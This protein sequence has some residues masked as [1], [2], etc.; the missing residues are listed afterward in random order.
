MQI[1]KKIVLIVLMAVATAAALLVRGHFFAR[2][3]IRNVVL[4][5]IDTCRADYLGC[6]GCPLK[7]T[8]RIDSIAKQGVLF[9]YAITP[10]PITLPAHTSMLTGTTPLYHRV[11]DN[12][13]YYVG[14]H[15]VNLAQILGKYRYST[16]AFVSTAILDSEYG[17]DKGFQIYEDHFTEPS[18]Q[19]QAVERKGGE[20]TRLAI[21]W[22]GQHRSEKFFLF[23]HYY[24]PHSLYAPPQ[25]FAYLFRDNLYAGEI[26]YVDDCIG[27]VVDARKEMNLDDS[28]LL[29]ITADHGEMLGEHGEKTHAY[30][31]YQSAIKV[32]LIFKLPGRNRAVRIKEAVG[33]IDIAPTICRL[34][35]IDVLPAMQGQDLSALLRGKPAKSDE[36]FLYCESLLPTK[37]KCNPLLGVVSAKWKYIHT[38]R[39]EL[40]DLAADPCEQ[41]NLAASDAKRAHLLNEH[42][43][44]MLAEMTYTEGGSAAMTGDDDA[45][46]RLESLGYIAGSSV[47]DSLQLDPNRQDPKDFIE[48]HNMDSQAVVATNNKR[49]D[50]AK[51]L[52]RRMLARKSDYAMPYVYLGKVAFQQGD[53]NEGFVNY[54]KYLEITDPNWGEANKPP[55]VYARLGQ[56]NFYLHNIHAELA[57][58]WMEKGQA[59]KA[60][61]HYEQSLRLVPGQRRVHNALAKALKKQG[62]LDEA[63]AECARALQGDPTY[64][65]GHYNLADILRLQEKFDEAVSH[66]EQVMTLEPESRAAVHYDLGLLFVQKKDFAKAIDHYIQASQLKPDWAEPVERLALIYATA[67][68]PFRQPAKAL[69]LAQKACTISGYKS[70]IH[71]RTLAVAF[72]VTGDIPKAIETT[73]KAIEIAEAAQAN[74]LVRQLKADIER[75]QRGQSSPDATTGV[76]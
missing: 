49:F 8:P 50:E 26:A 3:Q 56:T 25:P 28:T 61:A 6:Y 69:E 66:Y 53:S 39:S 68:E 22:L 36:R 59:D 4:I 72:A 1:K 35:G 60:I 51:I 43:A 52:S 67:E 76:D 12:G 46:K 29:I 42:L 71:L 7:T 5:S 10:V 24:D 16:A 15:N 27:Q 31:I 33:L 34:L 75:Y 30:F 57:S 13:N 62:R 37:Y 58:A 65:Q 38:T 55:D 32:P 23:L 74:D 18:K 73:Q 20:T 64:A 41:R 47:D 17:L 44:A 40:Y 45:I 70:P 19:D 21:D 11:H 63:A 54:Y 9:E 14:T 2:R 48:L